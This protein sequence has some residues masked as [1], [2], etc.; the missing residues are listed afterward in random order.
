VVAE[1][2]PKG[3][4]LTLNATGGVGMLGVGVIGAVFLGF[5][6]DHAIDTHLQQQQP[7]VYQRVSESKEWV[8]GKYNAV[9]PDKVKLLPSGEQKTIGE[10]EDNAK[11]GALATVAIFPGIMLVCYLILIA[12]F[13]SRGG[14]KAQV[15]TGHSAEDGKFTGGVVGPADP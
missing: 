6:Q 4:A 3:G 10:I 7:A 12:Y 8:F 15:L 14:Y 1:Q 5:V 13:R 2:S 9:N 11:R